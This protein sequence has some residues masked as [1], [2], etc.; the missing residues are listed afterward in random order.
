VNSLILFKFLP[1]PNLIAIAFLGKGLLIKHRPVTQATIHGLDVG[2]DN[3]DVSEQGSGVHLIVVVVALGVLSLVF[4]PGERLV[5]DVVLSMVPS[6]A[7]LLSSLLSVVSG[8]IIVAALGVLVVVVP[9]G[10]LLVVITLGVAIVDIVGKGLDII[11]SI[12]HV[13]VLVAL[14][15]HQLALWHTQGCWWQCCHPQHTPS[16]LPLYIL[17]GHVLAC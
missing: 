10:I 16:P 12:G 14:G 9:R 17:M 1:P 8:L 15:N 4:S 3:I 7:Y 11:I 5:N 13:I 2:H 6:L